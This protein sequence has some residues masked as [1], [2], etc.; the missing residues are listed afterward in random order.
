MSAASGLSKV[1]FMGPDSKMPTVPLAVP[2]H[3]AAALCPGLF[4][5]MISGENTCAGRGMSS[6][7][8]RRARAY[9]KREKAAPPPGH[10]VGRR[11]LLHL[12]GQ[13]HRVNIFHQVIHQFAYL[14]FG[15]CAAGFVHLA[16]NVR[17]QRVARMRRPARA[18]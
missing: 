14:V 16:A 1:S 12:C 13:K 3:R 15:L 2:W 7:K 17:K 10:L 5:L 4:N 18:A 9:H 8:S 11:R 6:D